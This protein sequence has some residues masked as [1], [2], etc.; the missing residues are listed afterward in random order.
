MKSQK[1]FTIIEL[2]VVI[3]ILGIL[4]VIAAPKLMNVSDDAANATLKAMKG[5]ID[6]A[7]S[8]SHRKMVIEGKV[9]AASAQPDFCAGCDVF[10]YGYPTNAYADLPRL[11]ENMTQSIG[12]TGESNWLITPSFGGGESW[13]YSTLHADRNCYLV[14]NPA[15]VTDKKYTLDIVKCE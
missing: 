14:Y 10:A 2:I 3:V 4:V 11:V 9:G 6:S 5:T 13:I 8:L 7:L 12:S 15:T 1:G